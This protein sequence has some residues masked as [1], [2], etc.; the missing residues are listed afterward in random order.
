MLFRSAMILVGLLP[1]VIT[2]IGY[3][4]VG[5]AYIYAYHNNFTKKQTY[6]IMSLVMS[7]FYVVMI[8]F[9]GEYFGLSI[10]ETIDSISSFASFLPEVG[11]KI[12]AYVVTFLTM[13]MEV[14]IVKVSGDMV[15]TL[16]Q[17]HRKK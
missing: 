17:H 8:L 16:L 13:L 15:I 12:A 7:V 10:V 2:S 4:A 14:F 3:S 6:L 1:T 11:I 9:F 5:L